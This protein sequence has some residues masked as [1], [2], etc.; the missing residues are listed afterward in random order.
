MTMVG[1]GLWCCREPACPGSTSVPGSKSQHKNLPSPAF[2]TTTAFK[3]WPRCS[4]VHN[5]PWE[6]TKARKPEGLK[7]QSAGR[8]NPENQRLGSWRPQRA[9]KCPP[10]VFYSPKSHSWVM[11]EAPWL[12]SKALITSNCLT[13][14]EGRRS[15]RCLWRE[16]ALRC[17]WG[18]A[19]SS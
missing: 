15:P 4:G 18:S 5:P 1:I 6:N 9:Q 3:R 10:Q 16:A 8:F 7:H 14:K 11:E 2:S 19:L 13:P 17:R 12:Q